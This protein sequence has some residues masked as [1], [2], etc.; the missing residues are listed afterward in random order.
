MDQEKIHSLTCVDQCALISIGIPT[1]PN[2]L[3]ANYLVD[4]LLVTMCPKEKYLPAY[5]HFYSLTVQTTY[6]FVFHFADSCRDF[7][8][9]AL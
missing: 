3:T 7:R 1:K 8:Q 5:L 2:R 9:F 4:T 6:V